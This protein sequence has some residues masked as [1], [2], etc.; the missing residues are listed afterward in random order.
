[1][2]VYTYAASEQIADICNEINKNVCE[3]TT[4]TCYVQDSGSMVCVDKCWLFLE[5]RNQCQG[6][7]VDNVVYLSGTCSYDDHDNAFCE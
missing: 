5:P 6:S 3:L 7:W 2:C 4:D 1:M